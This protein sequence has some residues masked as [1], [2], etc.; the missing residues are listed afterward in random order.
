MYKK[1]Y[2]IIAKGLAL[3][4]FEKKALESCIDI[5]CNSLLY[6]DNFDEI[7]FRQFIFKCI[8]EY[9]KDPFPI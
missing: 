6:Y 8:E 9:E 4:I 2:K 7:K 5:V 1:D 3:A